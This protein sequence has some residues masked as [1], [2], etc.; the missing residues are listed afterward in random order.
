MCIIFAFAAKHIRSSNMILLNNI[1]DLANVSSD[2]K[3]SRQHHVIST[4]TLGTLCFISSLIAPPIF[5][6][7][8]SSITKEHAKSNTHNVD[9]LN[10]YPILKWMDHKIN[11]SSEIMSSSTYVNDLLLRNKQLHLNKINNT[12]VLKESPLNF[13][14]LVVRKRRVAVMSQLKSL[15]ASPLPNT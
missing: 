1:A 2:F 5:D 4:A 8:K 9:A 11:K 14:S 7:I 13:L 3:V 12:C 15:M 6:K 10:S